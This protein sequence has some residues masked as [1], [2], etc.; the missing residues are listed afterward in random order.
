MSAWRMA[1]Q[2]LYH[3]TWLSVR[4]DGDAVR[5]NGLDAALQAFEE[6]AADQRRLA[7]PVGAGNT[8]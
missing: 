8:S 6:I 7:F 2:K 3:W 5:E 1:Q 4:R